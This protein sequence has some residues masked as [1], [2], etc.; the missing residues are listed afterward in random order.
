[1]GLECMVS[2]G[3]ENKDITLLVSLIDK[4]LKSNIVCTFVQIGL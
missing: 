1:M 2:I 3:S 4:S